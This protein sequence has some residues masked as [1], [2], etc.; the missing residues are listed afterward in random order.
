M[1][2]IKKNISIFQRLYGFFDVQ[3]RHVV[4]GAVQD[5]V[6]YEI[7][8]NADFC[9]RA[10]HLKSHAEIGNVFE[11][12][13]GDTVLELGCGAG[14]YAAMLAKIGLKVTAVDPFSFDAWDNLSKLLDIEFKSGVYAEDLPYED[15][16][17][18]H[19]S[20]M[21]ALLY[22]K[23]PEK[24][25]TEMNRVMKK[26]G[27]LLVRTVNSNNQYTVKTGKKLD[28]QSNNL[29]TKDELEALIEKHGFKIQKSF[30]FGYWPSKHTD[31]F[32]YI[33]NN[34]LTTGFKEYI[35]TML[36]E[37]SRILITVSATKQ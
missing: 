32:W 12:K 13:V 10:S 25:M 3:T 30:T 23:D 9:K 26:G 16:S 20:C 22:F 28:P 8:N 15:E 35:G 24:A 4:L 27:T 7:A 18:D 31:L 14:R 33:S 36:P 19:V 37:E 21:G 6:N 29:Y 17:F 2:S 5:N 1:S 34:F 11:D